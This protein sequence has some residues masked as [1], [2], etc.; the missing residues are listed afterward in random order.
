MPS[1]CLAVPPPGGS[2]APSGEMLM[3]QAA[4]SASDVTWPSSGP[5]PK[6][7]AVRITD[8]AAATNDSLCIH[9]LDLTGSA[10]APSGDGVAVVECIVTALG[11]QLFARGLDIAFFLRRA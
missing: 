2:P 7:G 4:I 8:S 5:C 9:M 10:N 3:S 6:H 11:N 1:P